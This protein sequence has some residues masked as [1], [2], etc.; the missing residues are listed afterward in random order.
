M[1]EDL[2]AIQRHYPRVF[3]ACHARHARSRSNRWRVSERD[4]AI[5]AHLSPSEGRKA[6]ELARHL[7]IGLPTLSEALRRLEALGYV[8]RRRAAS[9]R[10][11]LAL[12]LTPAGAEALLGTSVLD[13]ERLRAALARLTREERRT[14]VRGLELLADAAERARSRTRRQERGGAR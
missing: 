10:R 12:T 14:A 13:T 5:L 9:D 2:L 4:G 6:S 7:G 3:H 11:A 1:D 8:E